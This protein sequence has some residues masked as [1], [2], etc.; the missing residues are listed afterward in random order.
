[1]RIKTYYLQIGDVKI[2]SVPFAATASSTYSTF[3]PKQAI[4]GNPSSTPGLYSSQLWASNAHTEWLSIDL[5]SMQAITG[6]N[7]KPRDSGLGFPVDFKLQSSPDG[8][9]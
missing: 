9:T 4:D 1:M 6:F 2:E 5:G 3:D 8:T 7:V